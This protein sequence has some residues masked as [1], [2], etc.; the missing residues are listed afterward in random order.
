MRSCILCVTLALSQATVF[1]NDQCDPLRCLVKQ[2]NVVVTGKIQSVPV[3]VITESGVV[4]YCVDLSVSKV[5]YRR[6][7]S[8]AQAPHARDFRRIKRGKTIAVNIIRFEVNNNERPAFLKKVSDCLLFLK[9]SPRSRPIWETVD[10]WF[11]IQRR[12]LLMESATKKSE[13]LRRRYPPTPPRDQSLYS[14]AETKSA[15]SDLSPSKF[16]PLPDG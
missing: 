8:K 10:P 4:N 15:S 1:A 3:G 12:N 14:R 5:F 13:L 6:A 16:G 7:L 2:S 11:G 9:I